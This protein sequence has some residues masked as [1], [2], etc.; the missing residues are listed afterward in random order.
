[1]KATRATKTMKATRATKAT[2]ATLAIHDAQEKVAEFLTKELGK[3]EEA[4][5][6]IKLSHSEE[7]WEGKVEVTE[8]N[9]YM[10]KLGHPHIFDKNIYTVQLD[11]GLDVVSYAQTASQERSYATEER[12]EL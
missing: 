5:R 6:F 9:E 7:G 3:K 12:E 8:L 11:S 2:K 10:K 1:M 4:L